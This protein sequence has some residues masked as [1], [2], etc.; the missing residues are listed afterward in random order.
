VV[1]V[2]VMA[3]MALVVAM[4]LVVAMTVL[5]SVVPMA[6]VLRGGLGSDWTNHQKKA[7]QD[8]E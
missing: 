5:L 4:N 2:V 7:P 1:G 3:A 6:T 8:W